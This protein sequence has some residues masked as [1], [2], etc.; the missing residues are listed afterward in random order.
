M[1]N[2]NEKDFARVNG[3]AFPPFLSGK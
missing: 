2:L 3:G 1:I